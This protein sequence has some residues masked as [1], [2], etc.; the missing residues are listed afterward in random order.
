MRAEEAKSEI[1]LTTLLSQ[2]AAC[3]SGLKNQDLEVGEINEVGAQ[4]VKGGAIQESRHQ[5]VLIDMFLVGDGADRDPRLGGDREGLGIE[6][7]IVGGERQTEG[8]GKR[9]MT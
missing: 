2:A 5:K 9:R 1:R 7:L 6:E 8:Q 4:L 3:S